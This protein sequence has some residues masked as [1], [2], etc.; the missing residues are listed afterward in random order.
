M[1]ISFV[2]GTSVHSDGTGNST[3]AVTTSHVG[4]VICLGIFEGST[5]ITVSSISGGGASGW[6]RAGSPFA[7]T[8]A[9]AGNLEIWY[10]T[11]ATVGSGTVTVTYSASV[12]STTCEID[13]CQFTNGNTAT[14]WSVDT[15]GGLNTTTSATT[16]PY[17]SLSAANAGELYYGKGTIG[18]GT[19]G[20]TGTPATAVFF[21][22]GFADP[23]CYGLPT[24]AGSYQPVQ[25]MSVSTTSDAFAALLIASV[26]AAS[27]PP[28]TGLVVGQAVRRAAFF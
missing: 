9:G 6:A 21:A 23:Y 27:T 20:T 24:S 4:D 2:A 7:V 1:T 18:A 14:T 11:V 8:A 25:N 10:G 16:I 3:L 19:S 15:T 5:S 26:P 28:P 22:D 12:T 17:P 13:G